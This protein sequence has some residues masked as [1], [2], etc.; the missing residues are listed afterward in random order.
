VAEFSKHSHREKRKLLKNEGKES[1]KGKFGGVKEGRGEK[2]ESGWRGFE[3]KK[4]KGG[5][6]KSEETAGGDLPA[7]K[8][9][10][11]KSIKVAGG[12]RHISTKRKNTSQM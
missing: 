5:M 1:N 7:T 3:E 8:K 9:G 10:G 12:A 6:K 4:K 2:W 11:E